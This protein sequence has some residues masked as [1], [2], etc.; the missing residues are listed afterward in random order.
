[1]GSPPEKSA[2]VND[3]PGLVSAGQGDWLRQLLLQRRSTYKQA[4]YMALAINLLALLT[5]IFSLQ[6]YDRVVA[7]AGYASLTALVLGMLLII[8]I[9]YSLR[10]GRALLMQRLGA[11]IE[12]HLSRAIFERLT[13]LHALELEKRSPSYWL[14][15]FKDIDLVRSTCAGAGALLLIDLPFLLLTFLMIGLI[16]WPVLPIAAIFVVGFVGLA[17]LS[18]RANQEKSEEEK[19]KMVNRDITIAE[20]SSA[21]MSLKA[22]GASDHVVQHWEKDY[23]AWMSQSLQ[24]S[25]ESDR[26]RDIATSMSTLNN[27]V[28]TS[29]GALAI[30]SQ[31]MTMGA[32]IAA[33]IL[34]GKMI[35]PLIQLVGQWRSWGA[36]LAAKRRLDVLMALDLDREVTDIELPRPVGALRLE[37]LVFAYPESKA[38]QI[39]DVSGQFGPNGLHAIV[40]AN[41]SGKSTLLKIMRGLYTPEQGRVVL[42]GADLVQFS[43]ADLSRW[44]GYL[45]QQVSLVSGTVRDNLLMAK[46][47]ASDE[48]ILQ[49]TRRAFAHDFLLD[50]PD[51]YGTQVSEGGRRFSGGQRKRIAIAQTLMQDPPVLLLDEPT[52]DLDRGAELAFVATLKE[53]S[54]DHTVV[55]VTH[56]PA[57]LLQCNGIV[58]MDKGK[59]VIAGA[60][61]QILPKLGIAQPPTGAEKE[62]SHAA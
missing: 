27:V 23:A 3:D 43:N 36:F 42:D 45:P 10:Q 31:Y 44:I 24:H 12:V 21:R 37:H 55:V 13:R 25:Q 33:N 16:A 18:G 8:A 28:M 46:P 6:V 19:Q 49:A 35:A 26:Y 58:V 30:L 61:A 14:G 62:L 2:R 7:H 38:P 56:S 54:R 29:V 60:A 53:L 9:D 22:M 59:V 34:A 40:G 47:D 1:M 32:L 15:M 17:V 50:L 52:S 20:L 5:A 57:L 48:E 39:K 51:G 41:G 11:E 4:L